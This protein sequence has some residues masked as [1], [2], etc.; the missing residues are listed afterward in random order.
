MSKKKNVPNKPLSFDWGRIYTVSS[1]GFED[2]LNDVRKVYD[3]K[4]GVPLSI[5]SIRNPYQ[6]E[7][8]KDG[9]VINFPDHACWGVKSFRVDWANT[10]VVFQ[11]TPV[12]KDLF[13]AD[14]IPGH[15]TTCDAG[16]GV[17]LYIRPVETYLKSN[18]L[19]HNLFVDEW[20]Y[21]EK[22]DL[23]SQL[24]TCFGECVKIDYVY[25]G[26]PVYID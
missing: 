15:H 26:V 17:D 10:A 4:E 23:E 14:L 1:S 24:R 12:N 16:L 21:M 19:Q 2:L 9:T 13:A 20:G 18:P 5:S 22:S 6:S 7:N 11:G 8:D 3:I 25:N